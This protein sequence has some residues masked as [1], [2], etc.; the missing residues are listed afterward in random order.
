MQEF[1]SGE[2]KRSQDAPNRLQFAYESDPRG[3]R[4]R[5]MGELDLATAPELD[6]VLD[7][8]G[9]DGH[10][11]MVID[12]SEVSFMDSMGLA[13]IVRAYRNAEASGR[14]VVLHRGPAQVQRLFE[15]TDTLNRFTFED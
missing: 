10:D 12:L 11:E 9:N 5:I 4:V 6:R 2:D 15:I 14:R 7:E 8:L 3:V 13:S 1:E